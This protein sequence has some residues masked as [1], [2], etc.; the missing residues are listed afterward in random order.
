MIPPHK[1]VRNQ[2]TCGQERVGNCYGV[3][4]KKKLC[5]SFPMR[6]KAERRKAD[7]T[8]ACQKSS[9][10]VCRNKY[11]NFFLRT[12]SAGISLWII[13][14]NEK[15]AMEPIAKLGQTSRSLSLVVCRFR[16][17]LKLWISKLNF[18]TPAE[19]FEPGKSIRTFLGIKLTE[20]KLTQIF[21]GF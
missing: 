1:K 18:C 21:N 3:S 10:Y 19:R 8:I 17:G 2:H 6:K 9:L 11:I 7:W 12:S 5:D 14:E 15:L 13:S 4:Q 20:L 16:M